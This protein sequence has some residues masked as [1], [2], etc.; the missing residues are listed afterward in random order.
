MGGNERPDRSWL[1]GATAM[2]VCGALAVL[3]DSASQYGIVEIRGP[4]A[5]LFGWACIGLAIYIFVSYWR[6]NKR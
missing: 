6:S 5:Q 4:Q 2:L 1:L 3:S